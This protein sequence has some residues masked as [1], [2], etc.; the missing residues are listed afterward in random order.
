MLTEEEAI[1]AMRRGDP[2]GLETVIALHQV[3]AIR[4]AMAITRDLEAAKDA[5]QAALL[6]AYDRI[7]QFDPLRGTF[8]QWFLGIVVNE[9]RK[10]LRRWS[11]KVDMGSAAQ[12]MLNA[13]RASPNLDPATMAEKSE[14]SRIMRQALD[15]LSV[16]DRAVIVL[17]YYADLDQKGVARA[18]GWPLGAVKIRLLRA[19]RR[20]RKNL[21]KAIW[22]YLNSG[23]AA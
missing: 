9:A 8:K 5:A 16:K 7:D 20:M 17:Y 12:V 15:Q 2:C 23:G 18:L 14:L 19:R 13:C 1:A 22:S 10:G 21:P 3:L 11:S 6:L 4:A